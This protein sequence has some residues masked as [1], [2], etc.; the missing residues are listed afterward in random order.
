MTKKPILIVLYLHKKP[1]VSKYKN[2]DAVAVPI[3]T[4]WE[5][6]AGISEGFFAIEEAELRHIYWGLLQLEHRSC[7]LLSAEEA[8]TWQI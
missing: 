2:F 6:L 1:N 5:T 7:K 3:I 4:A 8:L